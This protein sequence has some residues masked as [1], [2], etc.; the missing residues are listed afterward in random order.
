MNHAERM[1][2]KSTYSTYRLISFAMSIL[3]YHSGFP[4]RFI[5]RLGLIIA[6]ICFLLGLYFIYA[7][8]MFNAPIG[9]TSI[10]VSIFFST[11]LVLFSLGIIGEYIRKLWIH[12]SSL[13]SIQ[14]R[15]L[16]AEE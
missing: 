12:S 11:G 4:L 10:I 13:K 15:E 5:S 14:I 9:F 3:L 16:H 1:E 6:F 8:I 2:G 7:K